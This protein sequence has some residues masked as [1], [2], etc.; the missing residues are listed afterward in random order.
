MK[1]NFMNLCSVVDI[2]IL[3]LTE[4]FL[5]FGCAHQNP[6][7]RSQVKNFKIKTRDLTIRKLNLNEKVIVKPNQVIREIA[8]R[9]LQFRLFR[10]LGI[11]NLESFRKCQRT[12]IGSSKGA[13]Y[14]GSPGD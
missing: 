14:M 13:I 8:K 12:L 4:K 7:G 9:A 5:R 2:N 6:D 3:K 10:K 11:W 1:R